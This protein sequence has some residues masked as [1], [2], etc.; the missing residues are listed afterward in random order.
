[1][2]RWEKPYYRKVVGVHTQFKF[3]GYSCGQDNRIH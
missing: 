2:K 1:M 3:G